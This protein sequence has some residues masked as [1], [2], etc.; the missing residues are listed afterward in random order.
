[1]KILYSSGRKNFNTSI[2]DAQTKSIA[3][4]QTL[5]TNDALHR[6]Y[7]TQVLIAFSIR[8]QA[9]VYEHQQ[10]TYPV[11]RSALSDE[12]SKASHFLCRKFKDLLIIL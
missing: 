5:F 8:T 3:I 1:M 12:Q 9:S 2:I 6:L 7:N 4:G 10:C 11:A